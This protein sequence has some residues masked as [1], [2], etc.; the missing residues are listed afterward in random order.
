MSRFGKDAI[1]LRACARQIP[2]AAL[3]RTISLRIVTGVLKRCHGA[4]R[5]CTRMSDVMAV[6][7]VIALG[8]CRGESYRD[9]CRWMLPARGKGGRRRTARKLATVPGRST[10]CEARH[11]LG[12]PPLIKLALAVIDLL[13]R[14]DTPGAFYQGYRLMAVD[15]FLLDLPD[16]PENDRAFGRPGNDKSPGAFPQAQVLGLVE[17]GTHVFWRWQIKPCNVAETRLAAPLLRHLWANMLLLWDRG[18]ASY[19]LV[20]QVQKQGAQLLARWKHNRILRPLYYLPDGSYLAR[21]YP[22]DSDRRHGRNAI[23]VRVIEY[24]LRDGSGKP[25]VHRL[26][27]TLLDHMRH[28]AKELVQLYHCRW[29]EEI[30]IDEL[31]THQLQALPLRSQTPAGVVQEIY[32]LLLGH[33]VVRRAMVEAAAKAGVAP[34]RLSFTTALRILRLRISQAP[35]RQRRRQRQYWYRGILEEIAEE[36]LPQRRRRI[37][38]RV[39]KRQQSEWPK[40]RPIHRNPPQP[41]GSFIDSVAMIH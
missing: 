24:S 20:A 41:T 15:G 14:A 38:P 31:K 29:E 10:L 30:A 34:L 40:K 26:L 33:Y 32:G 18:F 13:A 37:N 11:R 7:F 6:L 23:E 16:T 1:A 2:F 17:C 3:Q 4:G 36:L 25:Q 22:N 12:I 9:V 19:A 27:T 35:R 21:I 28:P 39:I 8:L 5:T